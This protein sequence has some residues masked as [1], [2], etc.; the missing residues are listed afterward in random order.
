MPL[1]A[2]GL[3]IAFGLTGVSLAVVACAAAVP[4]ASNGYV[5]ARQMGGDAPMLAQVLT[6]QTALA[7]LTMPVFIAFAEQVTAR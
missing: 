4:S 6:I 1:I 7:V 5:L 3:G 2:I